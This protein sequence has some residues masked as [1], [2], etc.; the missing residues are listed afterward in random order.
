MVKRFSLIRRGR[1]P[2]SIP[3]PRC[4]VQSLEILN[5]SGAPRTPA[6]AVCGE[7]YPVAVTPRGQRGQGL[8]GGDGGRPG[9][10]GGRR[11]AVPVLRG[12]PGAL[13]GGGALPAHVVPRPLAAPLR[14]L[15]AGGGRGGPA[16]ARARDRVQGRGGDG[17]HDPVNDGRRL[18]RVLG[19]HEAVVGHRPGPLR[20]A[21]PL[22]GAGARTRGPGVRGSAGAGGARGL[23]IRAFAAHRCAV[24]A[25]KE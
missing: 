17:G 18:F 23:L 21:I 15:V 6:P 12:A 16:V 7:E 5:V 24:T 22:E 10:G 4:H 11:M 3:L 20:G 2:R 8:L 19:N 25:C 9:A 1:N 13:Q 14:R